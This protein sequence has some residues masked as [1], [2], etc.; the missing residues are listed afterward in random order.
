MQNG[1]PKDIYVTR[2][3]NEKDDIDCLRPTFRK[4][5]SCMV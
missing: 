1:G 2:H 5:A 3:P 4:L